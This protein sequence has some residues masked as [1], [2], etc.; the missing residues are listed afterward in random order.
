VYV[1]PG[2]RSPVPIAWLRSVEEVEEVEFE[3]VAEPIEL[4]AKALELLGIQR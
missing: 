2:C 3:R 1:R 4:Q